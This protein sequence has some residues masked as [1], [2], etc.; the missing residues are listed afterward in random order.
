MAQG[1]GDYRI[2]HEAALRD[3]LAGV[4]D[5][6]ATLGGEPASWSITEVGDGISISFSSS[7]AA[8]AASP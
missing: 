1:Q 6:A 5:L 8:A 7:R 2:L 4:A 3:Y